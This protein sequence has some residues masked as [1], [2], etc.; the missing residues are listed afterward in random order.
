MHTCIVT[1]IVRIFRNCGQKMVNLPIFG[2]VSILSVG[3]VPF[4]VAFAIFWAAN[5][6]TSY[7]W[8]GQD[9]LVSDTGCPCISLC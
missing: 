2:E 8:I 6:N 9:V 7:A 4:C 3:V 1:L 5:Q